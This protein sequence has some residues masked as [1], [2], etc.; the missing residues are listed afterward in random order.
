MSKTGLLCCCC[1]VVASNDASFG[2]GPADQ[3]LAVGKLIETVERR[4]VDPPTRQQMLLEIVQAAYRFA[5]RSPRIGLGR[6]ISQLTS[7]DQMQA[8]LLDLISAG[9]F[10]PAQLSTAIFRSERRAG[11]YAV[12]S[13]KDS[14]VQEQ[15]QANRYVGIG[16]ALN[17]QRGIPLMAKVLPNG[18][19]ARADLKDGTTMLEADGESLEGLRI[20]EVVKRLRGVEGSELKLVVRQPGE[21][22]ER[23]TVV[24]TRGVVPIATA[25]LEW[26]DTDKGV[27]AFIL[28]ERI[29]ASTA[30]EIADFSA[31]ASA[32]NVVGVIIDLR[33]PQSG[34]AHHAVLLADQLLSGVEIGKSRTA[35]GDRAFQAGPDSLFE[36]IEMAVLTSRATDGIAEWL[37]SSLQ[38][39]KRAI[40]VGEPSSGFGYSYEFVDVPGSEMAVRLPTSILVRPS[41]QSLVAL[42][43]ESRSSGEQRALKPAAI[44][45][46]GRNIVPDH[47]V[48]ALRRGSEAADPAR[49]L[50]VSILT[51]NVEATES[52]T[53]E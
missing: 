49:E 52:A 50:A 39:N 1:I 17:L 19:A 7:T 32:R 26:N 31:E 10:K 3:T 4:H 34:N 15:L 12:L 14:A 9:E 25:K 45:P 44:Q 13:R 38:D 48:Q 41:G 40:V 43:P 21:G 24:L 51:Q 37:A 22:A 33:H 46:D 2:A 27:V 47:N 42:S 18:P 5:N 29:G 53:G 20:T 36:G 8:F 35:M 11:A 16:I 23:E 30:Q 6:E 28:V